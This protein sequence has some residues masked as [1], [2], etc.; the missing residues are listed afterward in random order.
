[1]SDIIGW[2]A[3]Y[4]DLDHL[5]RNHT[6]V[7]TNLLVVSSAHA[8][9]TQS[10]RLTQDQ[11]PMA[12]RIVALGLLSPFVLCIGLEVIAYGT[13]APSGKAKPQPSPGHYISPCCKPEYRPHHLKAHSD[14]WRLTVGSLVPPLKW[15]P[16][17]IIMRI[18]GWLHYRKT[19]WALVRVT[20]PRIP[21][22]FCRLSRS[23]TRFVIHSMPTQPPRQAQPPRRLSEETYGHRYIATRLREV[24]SP[25]SLSSN[26]RM[27]RKPDTARCTFYNSIYQS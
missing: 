19:H 5:L 21:T 23:S 20:L 18:P 15:I 24:L 11:I 17:M 7:G 12:C 9:Q 27:V 6:F 26:P 8:R 22:P 14:H 3:Y 10:P 1:M 2:E 4:P 13:C 16:S 25:V